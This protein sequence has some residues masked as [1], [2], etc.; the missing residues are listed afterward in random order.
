MSFAGIDGETADNVSVDVSVEIYIFEAPSSSV[1]CLAA[2]VGDY[3][4]LWT[5]FDSTELNDTKDLLEFLPN[6]HDIVDLGPLLD[7]GLLRCMVRETSDKEWETLHHPDVEKIWAVKAMHHADTYFKLITA[8]EGSTIRLTKIDDEIYEDFCKE[9]PEINV[10]EPL[11]EVKHFKC[12][13]AKAKWR[14]WIVKYEK[15]VKDYNMGTLLRRRANED[16]SEDN[17]FFAT[18]MQFVAIEI[19]RNK[20][21]LNNMHCTKNAT[22]SA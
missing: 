2:G 20:K 15:K 3:R 22:A 13:K 1:G 18:R 12:D 6:G 10:E 9:F 4:I 5:I 19:A 11:Q 21:S 7:H 17:S 16:Y 8:M 14:D